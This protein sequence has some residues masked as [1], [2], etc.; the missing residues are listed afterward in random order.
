MKSS[1]SSGPRSPRFEQ[2]LADGGVYNNCSTYPDG[3]RRPRP[4]NWESLKELLYISR[5]PN[6]PPLIE[7]DFCDFE[8]N[9][10]CISDE[11]EVVETL[12][13]IISGEKSAQRCCPKKRSFTNF[14]PLLKDE[15]LSIPQPDVYYG[16][17]PHMLQKQVRAELSGFIVPCKK[18]TH[19]MLPNF[20]IE[21][22]GPE[23]HSLT[24][25]LQ[26][27][28]AGAVGARA[29]HHLRTYINGEE[30]F[31]DE[32]YTITAIITGSP[33]ILELFTCHITESTR[34][35]G[36]PEYH[37]NK[38]GIYALTKSSTAFQEGVTAF[39]NARDWAKLQR[40]ELIRLANARF[41][42]VEANLIKQKQLHNKQVSNARTGTNDNNRVGK[43]KEEEEDE[44]DEEDDTEEDGTDEDDTDEEDT[45][46][47][48]RARESE[49]LK[50]TGEEAQTSND[51]RTTESK[52]QE[53][54]TTGSRTRPREPLIH[55]DGTD[56][57]ATCMNRL[58][59]TKQPPCKRT[60]NTR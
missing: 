2:K 16:S 13:P 21:A 56:E 26:A 51:R 50:E 53:K 24:S 12:L 3:R 33:S 29:M 34:A 8:A 57:L 39:R 30:N 1:G 10:E 43:G 14:V 52:T 4:A 25:R 48:V 23:G 17:A 46:E 38:L 15:H 44:D 55:S 28:Y 58:T 45:D 60:K 31:D 20:F 9:D 41:A 18:D 49:G 19:P 7:E 59:P 36:S 54:R 11:A 5:P 6:T 35:D 32:A 22:K 40:E 37:M 27:C 47:E 42:V